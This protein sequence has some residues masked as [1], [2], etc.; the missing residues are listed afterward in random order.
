MDTTTV[1]LAFG[2]CFPFLVVSL[3]KPNEQSL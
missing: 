2:M 1:L 3:A